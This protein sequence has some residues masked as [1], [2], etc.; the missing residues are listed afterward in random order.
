MDRWI[1]P[2]AR[3]GDGVKIGLFTVIEEGAV[4]GD[5]VTVGNHVTIHAD[6]IIGAG[7]TIADQAVVGRWPRP[8]QTSTVQVDTALSPLSLGEGCTIGTHAVLYRG[9]RIGA[10][11][12]VADHAFVREQCL[13]G[14]RVLIGRG[15]AVE[16]RVEIGSCTKIQTNAYITAHTRL[17]EQVFIAP[18][19]TTTNDNYMGRTEERFRH[20][21]GPTVKRGARVGGGAIL[22][23]GVVIAEES[24]IAAGAVVHRDTE[25][26]TVYAG[27]P[28]KPL[29]RVPEGEMRGS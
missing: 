2:K 13:I 4:L 29:R 7:T 20:V 14:D 28:A 17:E 11:V 3:I 24:F 10:E 12:L 16:N 26:A 6:T 15:V 21:K 27:V 5:N 8:A 18:G 9:S 22:L 19:V 1:H 23:P 25:A